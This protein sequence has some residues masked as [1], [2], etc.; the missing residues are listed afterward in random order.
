MELQNDTGR[1]QRAK[2]H[3]MRSVPTQGPRQRGRQP[4]MGIP[5]AGGASWNGEDFRGYQGSGHPLASSPLQ[6]SCGYS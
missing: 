1:I 4:S 3:S 5:Q 6:P 2:P